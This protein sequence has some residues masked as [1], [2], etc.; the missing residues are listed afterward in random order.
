MSMNQLPG[1]SGSMRAPAMTTRPGGITLIAVLAFISGVL[2]LC[3]ATPLFGVSLIGLVI[4]TGVTQVLGVVG[5]LLGL[6]LA[7]GPILQI[8]FAYGAWN[9]RSWAWW[10]GIVAIGISVLSAI[11]SIV[12]SGGAAI[13]TALTNALLPIII[14]IY[15]LTPNVR[16]VF[17]R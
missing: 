9:L 4:P 8:I 10:F 1:P 7:L 14:F 12:G 6:F 17:N 5:I 16:S 13:H 11:V 3:G 15:L 2:G